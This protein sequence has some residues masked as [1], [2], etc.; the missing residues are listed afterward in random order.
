[1]DLKH[2]E[3]GER[4]QFTTIDSQDQDF[5]LDNQPTDPLNSTTI[6]EEDN[7]E[8]ASE[9]DASFHNAD[10]E[11]QNHIMAPPEPRKVSDDEKSAHRRY[12]SQ[13]KQTD[14]AMTLVHGAVR[15]R[16]IQTQ[17]SKVTPLYERYVSLASA[18]IDSINDVEL[19]D[20]YQVTLD[21]FQA[22]HNYWHAMVQDTIEKLE[23][24]AKEA[25]EKATLTAKLK[26]LEDEI[27]NIG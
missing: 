24:E 16:N 12:L 9:D 4:S 7:S 3:R 5:L 11:P 8:L 21:D 14:A 20:H 25:K 19:A 15:P 13:R 17:L 22:D 6:Q 23:T 2:S 18:D 10:L 26:A 27:D 1:M